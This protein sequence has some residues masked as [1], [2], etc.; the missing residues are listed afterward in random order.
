MSDIVIE[1]A[2]PSDNYGI[3]ELCKIPMAGNISLSMGR[4]PDYFINAGIQNQEIELFVCRQKAR[5]I[6]IFSVGKRTVFY[7]GKPKL[8]RYFSDL[9]IHPDF[10]K[11]LL[12]IKMTRFLKSDIIDKNEF[13]YTIIFSENK[14]MTDMIAKVDLAGIDNEPL[15]QR[16][17]LPKYS[18]CGSYCSHMI[19]LKSRRNTKKSNLL[20]RRA[21]KIDIEA[22]QFF[23]N[24]EAHKKQWYPSYD[25]SLL[26]DNY[27][28]D[29]TIS[30]F[31]LAFKEGEIVGVTGVWDQREFKQTVVNSYT[32]SLKLVRP[33]I[34]IM[35]KITKGF[36]LPETGEILNYFTVHTILTKGNNQEI[37]R[38]IIEKIYTDNYQ[39][40]FSYF[41]CGL[42]KNDALSTIFN[43]FTKR[44]VHGNIYSVSFDYSKNTSI[45][46]NYYFEAARI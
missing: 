45:T 22:M 24:R 43:D 26:Q 36:H 46:P 10:Q 21:K 42:D 27:Y 28:H 41:L 17:S 35:A 29:L 6:G 11:S 30:D 12:L 9:R 39:S 16:A 25:F 3:C 34:N 23:F 2:L 5:V 33:F 20:I 1:K 18:L 14:V 40:E 15:L 38:D 7:N 32:R 37:F 4:N 31:Y 19:S 13:V 44:V 8:I